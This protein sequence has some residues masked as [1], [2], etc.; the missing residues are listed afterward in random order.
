[1]GQFFRETPSVVLHAP[2][3]SGV[4]LDLHTDSDAHQHDVLWAD[5]RS[6]HA[7]RHRRLQVLLLADHRGHRKRSRDGPYQLD[8]RHTFPFSMYTNFTECIVYGLLS[9]LGKL[10]AEGLCSI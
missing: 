5:R 1:M 8:T 2:P 4:C 3:A 6:I 9:S 7:A 10:C